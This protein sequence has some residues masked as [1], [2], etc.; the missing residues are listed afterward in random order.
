MAMVRDGNTFK[1]FVDGVIEAT[2]TISGGTFMNSSTI[3]IGKNTGWPADL[4][5]WISKIRYVK[6]SAL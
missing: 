4:D 1:F 2:E 5:A 6:C 3:K